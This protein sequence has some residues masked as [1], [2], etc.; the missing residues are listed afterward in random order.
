M[1]ADEQQQQQRTV[2]HRTWLYISLAVTVGLAMFFACG[3]LGMFTTV[4]H[5]SVFASADPHILFPRSLQW[6]DHLQHVYQSRYQ[7][8]SCGNREC[9]GLRTHDATRP[10]PIHSSHGTAAPRS[11]TASPRPH[12]P[13][14]LCIG[15]NSVRRHRDYVQLLLTGLLEEI[16]VS[17]RHLVRIVVLNANN[18]PEQHVVLQDF[19]AFVEVIPVRGRFYPWSLEWQQRHVLDYAATLEACFHKSPQYILHLEDDLI[20]APGI[21]TTLLGLIGKLNAMSPI[22]HPFF[23]SSAPGHA[24]AVRDWFHLRLFYTEQFLGY[25]GEAN[26]R[27][28]VVVLIVILASTLVSFLASKYWWPAFSHWPLRGAAFGVAV[29]LLWFVPTRVLGRLYFHPIPSNTILSDALGGF[30]C[31]QSVLYQAR[32]IPDFVAYLRR[33]TLTSPSFV[34]VLEDVYQKRLWSTGLGSFVFSTSLFQHVGI[35]SSVGYTWGNDALPLVREA[36]AA[37]MSVSFEDALATLAHT[38]WNGTT[39]P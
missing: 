30:C 2:T 34:D 9:V 16:P 17:Q 19:E 3:A 35:Q 39:Q 27:L 21:W 26:W 10:K 25:D 5:S 12:D 22:A 15:I 6:R 36:R 11:S 13:L 14:M 37:L 29:F 8:Q 32:Y 7:Q 20:P 38:L 23:P 28:V 4:Y 33:N 1:Q 24:V 31:T 18:P